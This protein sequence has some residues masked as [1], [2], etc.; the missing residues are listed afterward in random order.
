MI[1]QVFDFGALS[2][3]TERLYIM[4]KVSNMLSPYKDQSVLTQTEDLLRPG[5]SQLMPWVM[6]TVYE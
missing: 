5:R 1:D 4:A 2:V 3:T 6:D